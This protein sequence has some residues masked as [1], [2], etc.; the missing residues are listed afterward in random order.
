MKPIVFCLFLFASLRTF[1]QVTDPGIH[2][3]IDS[4][5]AEYN[6]SKPGVAVAIVKDG[7]IDFK[8]G[9]GLANL[10]FEIPVT[11][12]TKFHI[13]SVSKQFTAFSIYLLNKQGKLSLEDDVRKY[14]PELPAYSKTIRIR[15]LL[16][17]TSGIRD[18]WALLTLAGWEMEDIITTEQVLKLLSAQKGLNFETGTQAGYSNSGYTLLAEIVAR[19]SGESFASFTK[20]NIFDP[21]GMNNTLFNDNFH[22]VI[23]NRADSYEMVKGQWENRRL[24][25]STAGATSL[26]TTVEDLAKWVLNFEKPIVGDKEMIRSFNEVSRFDNGDLVVWAARPN[27]TTYHAK[28]QLHWKHNGLSAISHGGHDAGFRAV[29][30]RFPENNFAIITLSNNEHYQMLGKVLPVID[31]YLKGTRTPDV[32]SSPVNMEPNKPVAY[33]NVLESFVGTYESEELS[34]TYTVKLVNDKLVMTHTRL[35]DIVLNRAGE[36]KFSGRNSFPVEINFER[37][38]GKVTGFTISNFGV[39]NLRF[40]KVE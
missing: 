12:E 5:F 3:K 40:V 23:K 7:R 22:N 4:I 2:R 28:G 9:Y 1:A 13:A 32:P 6:T 15:H 27:D 36:D 24:N 8:K 26:V 14:I 11:T 35:K 37:K 16:A 33:T 34:T 19:V 18:Q 39:K 25:Y 10:E 38:D 17:H 30:T 31:L 20:K 21:L 29:L